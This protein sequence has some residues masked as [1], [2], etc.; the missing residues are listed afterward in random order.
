MPLHCTTT[1]TLSSA[2]TSLSKKTRI[3]L[4]LVSRHSIGRALKWN[5]KVK[6]ETP[7]TAS[8]NKW[9][10]IE[11]WTKKHISFSFFLFF[12]FLACLLS[13]FLSF[14]S[15]LLS[16]FD[17]TLFILGAWPRSCSCWVLRPRTCSCWVLP[18]LEKK[19]GICGTRFPTTYAEQRGSSGIESV[20]TQINHFKTHFQSSIQSSIQSIFVLIDDW[21]IFYQEVRMGCP[22]IAQQLRHCLLQTLR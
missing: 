10:R 5:N 13:L 19:C 14:L 21:N 4:E 17:S 7:K 3:S 2:N 12:S 15:F 18:P 8:K 16:F 11:T 22:C 6:N 1:S 20:P 9:R